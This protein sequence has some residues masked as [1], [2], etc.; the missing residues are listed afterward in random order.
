[1]PLG[2]ASGMD[3]NLYSPNVGASPGG[4]GHNAFDDGEGDQLQMRQQQFSGALL[5]EIAAQKNKFTKRLVN[6]E[7]VIE[8]LRNEKAQLA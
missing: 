4:P 3:H 6:Q 8:Q 5:G 7:K 2:R 1:M